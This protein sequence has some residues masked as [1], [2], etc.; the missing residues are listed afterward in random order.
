M[1]THHQLVVIASDKGFFGMEIESELPMLYRLFSNYGKI[2][3][4]NME[5]FPNM[6]YVTYLKS[7]VFKSFFEKNEGLDYISKTLGKTIKLNVLRNESPILVRNLKD[8]CKSVTENFGP[9]K[10]AT[11]KTYNPFFANIAPLG[12]LNK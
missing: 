9:V 6:I 5:F 2:I 7:T 1:L 4:F 10:V 12:M 3:D 11:N 8:P